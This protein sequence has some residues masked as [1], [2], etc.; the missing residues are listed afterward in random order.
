MVLEVEIGREILGGVLEVGRGGGGR[1]KRGRRG[2]REDGRG[3]GGREEGRGWRGGGG[4]AVGVVHVGGKY[5]GEVAGW[6]GG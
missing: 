2:G 1:G 5:G 3:K 6:W 4:G